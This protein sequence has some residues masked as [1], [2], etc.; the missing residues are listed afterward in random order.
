MEDGS[1]EP[2]KQK[3]YRY[4]SWPGEFGSHSSKE[5]LLNKTPFYAESGGQLGDREF[6]YVT[7]DQSKQTAVVEIKDVQE[8][9]ALWTSSNIHRYKGM[10]GRFAKDQEQ[11]P[12]NQKESQK[13]MTQ[14]MTNV[15]S[16]KSL[17][18]TVGTQRNFDF[19]RK[20]EPRQ[21]S[22]ELGEIRVIDEGK[23]TA[24]SVNIR[25]ATAAHSCSILA[26]FLLDKGD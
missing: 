5:V 25:P 10:D 23:E 21:K 11:P 4:W 3:K 2:L 26:I 20:R 19:R 14:W 18:M 13:K 17:R 8:S 1:L 22:E 16:I 9:L 24:G 15:P 12:K 7:A 6:L